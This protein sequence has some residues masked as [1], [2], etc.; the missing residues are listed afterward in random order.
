[1][2]GAILTGLVITAGSL[3]C[4]Q[5]IMLAAGRRLPSAVAPAAGLSALLVV[6][7]IAVKLPGHAVTAAIA[8][9][10]AVA[11][12]TWALWGARDDLG[13]LRVGLLVVVIGAA[14]VTAIPFAANGRM[15]ILGQGL[16][17]DD[18]ASHL[19]FTEWLDSRAGDTPELVDDGY[20]L[21]PHA[22]VA[23]A[24][25][26]TGASL[27]EAFA[28][29]TGAI[30]VLTALTAYAALP[31]ARPLLRAPAAVLA[32]FSYLGAAYLAQGAFK[33]PML[34][35]ALLG[36]ALCLPALRGGSRA[37]ALPAGVIAAG[38]IY[39][40]S[41]PGLAWLIG[42]IVVWLAIVALRERRARGGLDLAGRLRRARSQ[43]VVIAG[44]PVLAA[45]PE[46]FRLASFTDFKA[47]NPGGEGERVG[48]GNL[49]QALSPFE[50]LGIWPSS[51]FRITP[52]R[53]SVPEYA[54]YLGAALALAVLAWGLWRAY[55]RRE[56]VLPAALIAG[57]LGY[58]GALAAGTP[59]TQAKALAIVSPVVMLIG[60]RG[61]LRAE[62][63]EGEE[64]DAAE[65][66]GQ[67]RAL[68]RAPAWVEGKGLTPAVRILAAL[69][70]IAFV[71]AAAF[72]SLLPLR[73]AAVGPEGQVDQLVGMREVLEGED[74]LFLGRE[75]FVAWE[76]IGA[77]VHAPIIH[78]Y[79]V[80]EVPSLYRATSTRAK[81]DFDTVP[82]AEFDADFASD[83][84]ERDT[85]EDF[86]W[87]ITTSSAQQSEPPPAFEEVLRTRDYVLWQRR[88]PLGQRR[89]LDE[90]AGP[91]TTVDCEIPAERAVTGLPGTA[92]VFRTAPVIGR[93]WEPDPGVT[94]S[95]PASEELLLGAGTW[96]ISLQY[97]ATQ[98][99]E[100]RTPDLP[101]PAGLE[102][103]LEPNLLFRGAAPFYP[104]GRIE[105]ARR[106]LVRFEVRIQRPP[107]VGRLVG[108]ETRGYLG[109]LAATPVPPHE[110]IPLAEACDR[111]L[112]WYRVPPSVSDEE[113]EKVETPQP[114]EVVES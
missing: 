113:L 8:A 69:A 61:L 12:S 63:V 10:I 75:S 64:A 82:P 23:A 108:A 41:F 36:F 18:M 34:G 22:L 98:P 56:S 40:Y 93:A 67:T 100:V 27:I 13:P 88:G 30:A 43:L 35:L 44:L 20:P 33:E 51:E 1:M 19:L 39:N 3:A 101:G 109:P 32:A 90:P 65:A 4:G 74:V 26:V 52:E 28:G 53:A 57:A 9:G 107:L 102:S 99:I 60:L 112:D 29:L 106:G 54:F 84:A 5:A 58:V 87:V 25:R 21:G 70:G 83:P 77:R 71:L 85:L 42:A 94:D 103:V 14:L 37:A 68:G 59:Y 66:R 62:P 17:N 11:V 16:V 50:A 81:F 72:S 91:G 76:L 24:A 97:A 96:D 78:N 80:V 89:T 15:G 47:F 73:Q 105:I 114:R 110:S 79:N 6:C 7:G 92:R 46:L 2:L 111:Y 95:E 38:T 45:V 48:L 31:G 104:V 86:E 55:R 49:R